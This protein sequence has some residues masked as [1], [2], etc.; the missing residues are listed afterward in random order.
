M[1]LL[2]F[3]FDTTK[4]HFDSFVRLWCQKQGIRTLLYSAGDA[5]AS[6]IKSAHFV[7][8]NSTDVFSERLILGVR[9]STIYNV[10]VWHKKSTWLGSEKDI[11]AS[12]IGFAHQTTR[13]DASLSL[14]LKTSCKAW[15]H[16]RIWMRPRV[17][18]LSSQHHRFKRGFTRLWP[19][20]T[21]VLS[22][23]LIR[24]LITERMLLLV[25]CCVSCG[26]A[27][28]A[29]SF[30]GRTV[31]PSHLCLLCGRSGIL[32]YLVI[33]PTGRVQFG[34]KQVREVFPA[35]SPVCV[36]SFSPRSQVW[37]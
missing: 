15:W 22:A 12:D 11:L 5:H 9:S 20:D 32:I 8:T 35:A 16:E 36:S 30:G 4:A 24:R 23:V 10:S 14:L 18:S 31:W 33:W 21:N 28:A 6:C 37:V 26:I 7:T 34:G 25:C 19:R 29:C 3:R 1:L 17:S 13:Q 27:S 2:W